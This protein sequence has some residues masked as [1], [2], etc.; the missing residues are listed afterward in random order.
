MS[1]ECPECKSKNIFTDYETKEISCGDCGF[2]IG[3]ELDRG[4]EWRAYT[5]DERIEKTRTGPPAIYTVHDKGLSTAIDR[6]NRD[7]RG[8][9]LKLRPEQ[10]R[11]LKRLRKW[12]RRIRV[13]TSE[14]RNLARATTEMNRLRDIL[15]IPQ[16]VVDNASVIYRK[17][18]KEGLV[19]GRSIDG[20]VI[21]A[22]R[23]SCRQ[24]GFMK[25]A[26]DFSEVSNLSKKEVNRYYRT[27]LKEIE[28]YG[29]IGLPQHENYIA[30][31]CNNLNIVGKTEEIANKIIKA[32]RKYKPKKRDEDKLVPGK[33]PYGISA[34]AVYI[35]SIIAGKK[36]IQKEIA[37]AAQVTEVTIRNR[38]KPLWEK[39]L[40]EV[41]V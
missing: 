22:I 23:L 13:Q 1:L 6:R 36:Q 33:D 39:L 17:A 21:G 29:K 28:Y 27:L 3:Y 10:R 31:L 9:K 5:E 18:I 2:V 14:E 37:E 34:A 40:F 32:A 8:Q 15:K 38:Y 20:M 16:Y 41:R 7:S 35:G 4:P 26:R 11:Q 12:Q 24:D 19:R 25:T 30:K